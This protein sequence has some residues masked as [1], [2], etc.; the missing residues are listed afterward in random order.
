MTMQT[1]SI[2]CGK[3]LIPIQ[4]PDH[5]PVQWVESR[6]LETTS[7]VKGAVEAALRHPIGSKQL[8]DL[9]KPGQ[10]VALVVTD[11][12]RKLP[13]EII[14]PILLKEL[15]A[16]GIAKIDITAAGAPGTPRPRPP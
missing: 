6:R 9:V 4:T 11:V 10:K 3:K 7:D 15:Q 13:E 12:T 16:G 5:V 1:Y 14:V 2:P 8:R